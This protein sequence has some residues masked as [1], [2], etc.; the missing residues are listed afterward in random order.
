MTALD[1]CHARGF[2][3][4]ATGGCNDVKR[5]VTECLRAE[6]IMRAR[7]NR[8]QAMEKHV[9]MRKLFKDIEQNS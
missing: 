1:E 9:Q 5:E 8:E 6:R 4:R 7:H 3:V 2:L